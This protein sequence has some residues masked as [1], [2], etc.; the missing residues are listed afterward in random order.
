M[1]SGFAGDFQQHM[2]FKYKNLIL[3]IDLWRDF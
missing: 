1:A 2:A 3:T